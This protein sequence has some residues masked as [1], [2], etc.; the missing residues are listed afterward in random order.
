MPNKFYEKNT[1]I[2]ESHVNITYEELVG[3]SDEGFVDWV[4][5]MRREVL[6]IWDDYSIP[7][8]SGGKSEQEIIAQ[9]NKMSEYPIN[10]FIYTDALED[11]V[12]DTILN[13]SGLGVE[14]DQWFDNMY[15]TR[16]NRS[17]K[18]DGHSVYDLFNDDQY[19]DSVVKRSHRHFRR[20][21]FYLHAQSIKKNDKKSGLVSVSSAKEWME[22]FI[23]NEKIFKDHDFILEEVKPP[24]GMNAGYFQLD[25]T[26][27]LHLTKE[28]VEYYNDRGILQHRHT[29]NIDLSS[30][31][32][33]RLYRIR[34]YEKGRRIFPKGFI[35]FRIGYVQP[36]VNFP[37]MTAKYLYER[38]TD[39]I[40]DQDIIN[41]YDPSSGWG[42]RILGAM[43]VRDDRRIHYI[44]TDPNPDNFYN[45][46]ADSKYADLADFYNSRTYRGN[47]FFSHTNTYQIFHECSEEIG[48]NPD[49]RKYH[50]EIDLIFTSP[51]YFNREA[52]SEDPKQSYK[53]YGSSYESWKEGFLR[54]TLETCYDFL[55]GDRYLL[56]NIADLRMANKE[57]LPLEQDSVDILESMGME[58]VMTFKMAQVGMPGSNRLTEDGKPHVKNFCLIGDKYYKY[59]PVFVFRKR[60]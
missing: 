15:K 60:D 45:D 32:A 19:L 40:K 27:L 52:Y 46:F 36:A 30:L 11:Q 48:D 14:A 16:I 28:E 50:G 1:H 31:D 21:G 9:F 7:P 43:S 12:D 34:L 41:I 58:Y 25:E 37:P 38:F 2:L 5:E 23:N 24:T 35:P 54:P 8:R 42:G 20:D 17:D 33:R 55:R 59:E 47:P 57:Y 53:K 6:R 29:S 51:P 26:D 4:K 18:D 39:H 13:T 22:A 44:G 10:K 3:L 49:F 56:W